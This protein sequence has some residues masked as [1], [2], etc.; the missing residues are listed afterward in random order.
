M[1]ANGSGSN[2]AITTVERVQP[3]RTSATGM[4]FYLMH[5]A[6]D[7]GPE[8]VKLIDPACDE[9]AIRLLNYDAAYGEVG[10]FVEVDPGSNTIELTSVLDDRPIGQSEFDLVNPTFAL[11]LSGVGHSVQ[12]GLTIMGVRADGSMSSPRG[13]THTRAVQSIAV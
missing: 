3:R 7:L 12:S 2:V 6:R 13:F 5:G 10:S 9:S 8:V 1:I 4:R 11:F